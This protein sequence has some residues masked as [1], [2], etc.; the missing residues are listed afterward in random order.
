MSA[1]PS[2]S[3]AA[4]RRLPER[5]ASDWRSPFDERARVHMSPGCTILDLGGGATAAIPIADRPDACRYVGLDISAEELA[6][7]PEGTYDETHVADA[8]TPLPALEGR[9]DL[10]VSWQVFEHVRSLDAALRN[11]HA[12]LR[13]GG[14]LVA[15]FTGAFA[16]FAIAGR[17]V[18]HRVAKGSMRWLLGRDPGTVFAAY[19]DSTWYSALERRLSVGWNDI[20]IV[21]LYRGAEYLRFAPPLQR[22][23]VSYENWARASERRNLATHY[24]LHAVKEGNR[25]K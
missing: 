12:Y 19:Y 17:I 15:L 10:I 20:E 5:Y 14:A 22:M 11:C 2:T 25:G 18:P 9:F 24:L 4:R 6:R 23:Y 16:F 7:A 13:P 1:R 8:G 21:P 3:R